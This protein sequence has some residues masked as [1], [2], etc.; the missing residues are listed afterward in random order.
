MG[1]STS[2]RNASSTA[3]SAKKERGCSENTLLRLYGL[4]RIGIRCTNI[5]VVICSRIFGE[6]SEL[7]TLIVGPSEV[8]DQ[9]QFDRQTRMH[10]TAS[11]S[12]PHF[13]NLLS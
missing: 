12:H 9:F 13:Q 1:P 11:A 8:G 10:T 2:R 4:G 6:V 3:R 5:G 7:D